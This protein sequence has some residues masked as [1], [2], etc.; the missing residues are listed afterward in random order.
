MNSRVDFPYIVFNSQISFHL[1]NTTQDSSSQV[2][3]RH[4]NSWDFDVA[5]FAEE[6]KP[7]DECVIHQ[8]I[9]A[10]ELH[11]SVAACE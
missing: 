8:H 6:K 11:I 10:D 5:L 4:C 1:H 9:C 7:K 2:K 3:I